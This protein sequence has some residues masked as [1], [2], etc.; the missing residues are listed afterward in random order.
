MANG[1]ANKTEVLLE[2]IRLLLN[3]SGGGGA[4]ATEA[5]LLSV[6]NAIVASD[7]DI[8]ILL[9][10]DTITLIVYQQIT[11]Y[12]TGAPT[13][14]YK[15]VNG[16]PFVPINPMEYLD[17][18]AV[19]NLLLT[20][21][22]AQGVTLDSILVELSGSV[23]TFN[24]IRAVAAGNIPAGTISGSVMNVGTTNGTLDGTVVEPFESIPIPTLGKNE[25]Y[26]VIPYVASATAI[27]LIQYSN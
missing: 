18:S 5:T 10:R 11:D 6:L 23:K 13:V 27:L 24:L 22:L 21:A 14:T 8:E 20:E 15:D 4:L 19:M 3:T 2:R 1:P 26:G 9:V 7:Q 12:T 17:P 25:T 16:T